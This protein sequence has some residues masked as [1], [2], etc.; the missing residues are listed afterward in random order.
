MSERLKQ[1][2]TLYL[3]KTNERGAKEALCA[4]AGVSISTL[5]HALAPKAKRPPKM[6]TVVR[7]ALACGLTEQEALTLAGDGASAGKRRAG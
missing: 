1:M 5:A 7:L 2:L 3:G 4:K 6:E